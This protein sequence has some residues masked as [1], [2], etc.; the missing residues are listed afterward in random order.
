MHSQIWYI[1]QIE[2][3]LSHDGKNVPFLVGILCN[4]EN[5]YAYIPIFKFHEWITA[6][7]ESFGESEATTYI[8]DPNICIDYYKHLR[9]HTNNYID[10]FDFYSK[11]DFDPNKNKM[12]FNTH[13]V[14]LLW[15]DELATN[16]S[17][18]YGAHV[19]P[20]AIITLARCTSYL[21]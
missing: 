9:E 16:V 3:R 21:G 7:L 11:D 12:P 17:S 19:E 1:G 10:D 15:A 6:T 8:F 13:T 20:D 14:K 4:I 5:V 2:M 18:C